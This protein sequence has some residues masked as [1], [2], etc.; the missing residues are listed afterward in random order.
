MSNFDISIIFCDFPPII[1]GDNKR[2][3]K[4]EEGT[5][6]KADPQIEIVLNLPQA[7]GLAKAL[8]QAAKDFKEMFH[9]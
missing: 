8:G 9:K 3:E 7:E 4:K 1:E 2:I 6:I 5:I